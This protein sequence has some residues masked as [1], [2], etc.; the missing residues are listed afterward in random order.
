MSHGSGTEG[1]KISVDA[2]HSRLDQ[3]EG[4]SQTAGVI[5][6]MNKFKV[7]KDLDMK[8]SVLPFLKTRSFILQT[9]QTVNLLFEPSEYAWQAV[10]Y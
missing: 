6:I 1:V 5:Q 2:C 10:C 4:H 9:S 8:I 3:C 7:V